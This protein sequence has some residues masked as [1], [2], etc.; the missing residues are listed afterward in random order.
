MKTYSIYIPATCLVE[1]HAEANSRE[2]AIEMVMENQI[3]IFGQTNFDYDLD[4]NNWKVEEQ[5]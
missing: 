2:E 1:Y 5:N 4:I 3:E